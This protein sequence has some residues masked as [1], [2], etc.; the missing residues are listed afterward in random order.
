[1]IIS[2]N[3]YTNLY[4]NVI[5]Y[6]YKM[7]GLKLNQPKKQTLNNIMLIVILIIANFSY[8]GLNFNN[9]YNSFLTD[10]SS[11]IIIFDILIS[12]FISYF[13]LILNNTL[14]PNSA[15]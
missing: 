9:Y 5:K 1:M 10:K 8:F 7:D 2:K 4:T 6:Q 14:N 11:N 15:K 3:I 12:Q 13:A